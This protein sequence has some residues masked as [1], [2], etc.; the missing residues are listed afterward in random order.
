MLTSEDPVLRVEGLSKRF[1]K[2]QAVRDVSFSARAGEISAVLGPN[3]AGKTTT[4]EC[5]VGLRAADSGDISILGMNPK[6]DS[7]AVR[8]R[9]GV[10]LQDGG[11]PMGA[12]PLEVLRHFSRLYANPRNVDELAEQLGITAFSNRTIRR[13]SGGQRQRVALAAALVGGPSLVFLDEP[14]AGLDPQTQLVVWELVEQLRDSGVAVVLTT[15]TMEDA[16]R[17]ADQVF[18][19]DIGEVVAAGTPAELTGGFSDDGNCEF[20]RFDGPADLDLGTLRLALGANR[21]AGHDGP[22]ANRQA[23]HGQPGD[24][25]SMSHG[26]L[27]RNGLLVETGR[28][29]AIELSE[30][31]SGHY[32]LTGRITPRVLATVTAWCADHDLMPRNLSV[33]R[34]TLE[35]VF[36]EL[37][38]RTLR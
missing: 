34:R 5:C 1:G 2:T 32:Q 12:R 25:G 37:T 3:G 11:L 22:G 35:D 6:A 9:T 28:P 4:I 33:G 16:E 38:G 17:L 27:D 26:Q 31:P 20:L 30:G 15:H 10:M 24:A 14:T 13:L 18:I 7:G 29:D 23:G 19:F 21:Q 8:A 36:L